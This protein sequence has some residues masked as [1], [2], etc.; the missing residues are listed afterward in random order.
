MA[1][2]LIPLLIGVGVVAVAAG[3]KKKRRPTTKPQYE[4][5][6]DNLVVP[7]NPSAI[8]QVDKWLEVPLVSIAAGPAATVAM[9]EGPYGEEVQE[10]A[11]DT[12]RDHPN[13]DFLWAY[14]WNISRQAFQRAAPGAK[15]D[16]SKAWVI[17]AVRTWQDTNI[18]TLG[19]ETGPDQFGDTIIEAAEWILEGIAGRR[20]AA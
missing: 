20:R 1:F 11:A 5:L 6:T 14:D 2:P 8:L 4:W 3:G 19:A 12:A 9:I 10:I 7:K 13:I 16:P 18:Q 17:T 15:A